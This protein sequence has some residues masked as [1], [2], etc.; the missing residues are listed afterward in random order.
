[1]RNWITKLMKLLKS[2]KSSSETRPNICQSSRCNQVHDKNS[3]RLRTFEWAI[4]AYCPCC[5]LGGCFGIAFSMLLSVLPSVL[6]FSVLPSWYYPLD[7]TL[8]VLLSVLPSVF[9]SISPSVLPFVSPS[10][11]P[12]VLSSVLASTTCNC[13]SISQAIHFGPHVFASCTRWLSK[14]RNLQAFFRNF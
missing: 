11:W 6:L 10:V 5:P 13:P 12:P 4:S 2:D 7:I 1:M 8:L 9:L 3:R 14:H